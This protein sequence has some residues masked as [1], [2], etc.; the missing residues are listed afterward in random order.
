VI[1][2]AREFASGARLRSSSWRLLS[3]LP[4]S[5]AAQE[6]QEHASTFLGL[7]LWIW[8]LVNL[9]A[10]LAVLLYFVARPL[11]AMFR[12]RQLAVE[13]RLREAKALRAEAERLGAEVHERMARLD[14]E[15]EEIR[16]RGVA[17][18]E[19]ERAALSEKADLEVERVR[20]ESEQEIGRHLAAARLELRRTAADLTAA[21]AREALSAQITDE[22][23]RRLLQ[24]G[25]SQL[26]EESVRGSSVR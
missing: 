25:V 5:L 26:A 15:I 4:L 19:T 1:E 17:D 7:P 10:F 8:Q 21:A 18:G 6:A 22:D 9:V 13:E 3:M 20:R 12:N 2:L 16:G 11:A 24:E 23:R 14:S